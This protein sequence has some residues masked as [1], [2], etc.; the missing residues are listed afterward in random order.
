M[1]SSVALFPGSFDPLTR[2]HLEIIQRAAPL[3][4]RLIVVVGDNPNKRTMFSVAERQRF[5][6][7]STAGLGDI[8]VDSFSQELLVHY[9][10]RVGAATVV[11]GLRDWRDFAN[12]FQQSQ[13]NRHML[14]ALDTLFFVAAPRNRTVS[15]TRVR[16]L[17]EAGEPL[18]DLIPLV[19]V[20]AL[21]QLGVQ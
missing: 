7:E 17:I 19:V 14:P 18:G 3:F 16:A 8:V 20:D 1:K 21:A 15:S 9:A 5:V 13:M 6:R 10:E 12:E 4:E 2:G 11:R